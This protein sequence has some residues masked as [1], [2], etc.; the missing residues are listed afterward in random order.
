[1][2]RRRSKQE[3]SDGSVTEEVAVQEERRLQRMETDVTGIKNDRNYKGT[4][5]HREGEDATITFSVF[6]FYFFN[7]TWCVQLGKCTRR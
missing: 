7:D 1:M 4:R 5:L 2:E 3:I 6:V